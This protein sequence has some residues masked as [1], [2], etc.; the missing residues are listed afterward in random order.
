MIK[1]A[2]QE[3]EW[4]ALLPLPYSTDV[5]SSDFQSFRPLSNA[6]RGVSFN[7]DANWR[8]T[9]INSLGRDREVSIAEASQNSLNDGMK[10]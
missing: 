8:L 9:W 6:L 7:N 1:A 3:L 2:S 4:S 5:A 10:L